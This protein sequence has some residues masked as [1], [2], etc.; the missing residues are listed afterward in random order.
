MASSSTSRPIPS[1]STEGQGEQRLGHPVLTTW[2][3]IAQSLAIGPIFSSAFVA[4]LIAGSAGGAAPLSTLIGAVGVLALGWLIAFYARRGGGAGAIYDYLRRVNPAVGLFAASIYFLGALTLDVG[5]FLVV[6]LL[7][8]QVFAS[9]LS[10]I[11][12]WWVFSLIALVLIFLINLLGIRIATRVQLILSAISVIPLLILAVVIIVHGGAVGNTFQ[13]FNPASVPSSPTSVPTVGIFPGIL[14]AITLFIGFET[15]ASLGEET[16]NPRHSIPRAVIGTVL[17]TGVFYLL[18]IYASDIGFGLNH[19]AQWASDPA[20][21]DTLATRYV[22]S[23]L[24]VL[25][26][27]AVLFDSLVVMSA[28]MAT[29]SRGLFA[30]ARHQ[31]LPSPLASISARF[32]TPLG[33]IVL[34]GI[35][36]LLVT[37]IVEITQM[38]VA[39]DIAPTNV[40][41]VFGIMSTIGSLLIE[42]IYI[43]L[44]LV[45][46]RL[47][48]AEPGKWWRWI[49]LLVAIV[50]PILGIY[51]SVVPFPSWP[52]N[53]GV[54]I[55]LGVVALSLI[56]TLIHWFVFPARLGK[57]SEPHPWEAEE[58]GVSEE[59]AASAS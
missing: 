40:L 47:L 21:L 31:L 22:G 6:G 3:A 44:C 42:L 25:V 23:W 33:G 11:I 50:T 1:A 41:T 26:D 30:L 39:A 45:A 53:L 27:I 43:G 18:M 57:A 54:F 10:L 15:S 28:F 12:P 17:I 55:S 4:Y 13:A 58:L 5:G 29:T 59:V 36:A 2:D 19:S 9:Y 32:R 7:A 46:I 37:A 48:A 24:A 20:P 35:T 52:Q 56:W 16:R 38:N 34:V 8:A 51:G 49:F 14:F